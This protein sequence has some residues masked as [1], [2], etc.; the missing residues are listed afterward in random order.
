MIIL[1][2]KLPGTSSIQLARF[3]TRAQR[4]AKLA[5]EVNVLVA[6]SQEIRELNR[7][8]RGRDEVTD[9]LS[10]PADGG[11]GK[12]FAGDIAI[13]ADLAAQSA[14][15]FGHAPAEELKVLLLHGVL[16][17]AGYDHERD[18][19]LMARTENRLRAQLGL[20]AA[21]IARSRDDDARPAQLRPSYVTRRKEPSR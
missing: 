11:A 13:S 4:A 14:R 20:P 8:Y 18:N 6:G 17:L 9:V 5:G 19:G 16:H 21:L 7:R 2:K 15:Q 1:K 10:F 12:G 3:L